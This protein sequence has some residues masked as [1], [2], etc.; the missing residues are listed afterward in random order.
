MTRVND[1]QAGFVQGTVVLMA[2]GSLKPIE[3]IKPGDYVM[4]FDVNSSS[5]ELKPRVVL[6]TFSYISRDV[7]EVRADEDSVMVA[8]GQLFLTPGADWKFAHETAHITDMIGDARNF[9]VIKVRTGNHKIYDI[10][11][12]DNHSLVANG[13]RVH[14]ALGS[15][16]TSS[17]GSTGGTGSTSGSNQDSSYGGLGSFAGTLGMQG[18]SR[19][20]TTSSRT[21]SNTSSSGE[22][23][24]SSSSFS[25]NQSRGGGGG[26]Y[27]ARNNV[28]SINRKTKSKSKEPAVDYKVNAYSAY[29][30]INDTMSYI[31]D[32]MVTYASSNYFTVRT[33]AT[34]YTRYADQLA[35]DA[36]VNI[37][38]SNVSVADK[39][40]LVAYHADII[41]TFDNIRYA[42]S[43]PNDTAVNITL[44]TRACLNVNSFVDRSLA[45]LS[46]YIGSQKSNLTYKLP[47]F[48]PPGKVNIASIPENPAYVKVSS[49]TWM[50]TL[51]SPIGTTITPGTTGGIGASYTKTRV[52]RGFLYQYNP[53]IGWR[54]IGPAD[55]YRDLS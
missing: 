26:G 4:S 6:D 23:A 40:T 43:N 32:I 24:S 1:R 48:T 8:Q 37:N 47:G 52:V 54:K 49:N 34:T 50:T 22:P 19:P 7:L 18:P 46:K 21:S 36:L 30:A 35:A 41:N 15:S 20:S 5:S 42:W 45:I 53:K 10:M 12:D 44:L 38:K 39:A 2:D 13:F 3:R 16:S 29:T 9:D 51:P 27:S 33:A 14:N 28:S 31:C 25:D 11:V 55:Q 17:D